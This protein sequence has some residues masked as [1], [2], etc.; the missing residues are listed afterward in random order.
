MLQ[1]FIY[2]HDSLEHYMGIISI[3]DVVRLFNKES[4]SESA[5]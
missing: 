5:E 2:R 1:G 3:T 4:A